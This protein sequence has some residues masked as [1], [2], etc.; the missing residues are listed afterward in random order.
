MLHFWSLAIEEQFYLAWPIVVAGALRWGSVRTVRAAALL[1]VAGS[2]TFSTVVNLAGGSIDQLYLSTT[3]RMGEIGIGAVFATVL[4]LARSRHAGGRR[5]TGATAVTAASI[6]GI[7]AA[8]TSVEQQS[9]W[10]YPTGLLVHAVATCVLIAAACRPGWIQH[11]LGARL[12]GVIGRLSYSLYLVHWPIYLIVDERRTGID[13]LTLF[14]LRLAA[15]VAAASISYGVIGQP[16][17]RRRIVSGPTAG[18]VVAV[19][20]VGAAAS[21][22]L[23][24]ADPPACRVTY[25][26]VS[27]GAGGLTTATAVP[28]S[29]SGARKTTTQPEPS[30]LSPPSASVSSSPAGERP[31]PRGREGGSAATATPGE[32][33]DLERETALLVGDSGMFG[34]APA[35]GAALQQLGYAVIDNSYPGV[36]VADG[37]VDWRTIWGGILDQN[38]VT[39]VI[40]MMGGWDVEFR[41]EHGAEAYAAVL[42]DVAELLTA[43]GATVL[44]ISVLPGGDAHGFEINADLEALAWRFSASVYFYDA[45]ATVRDEQGAYPRYIA[46]ELFRT[47]DG[48][49]LCQAGAASLARGVLQE[50]G[51][52]GHLGAMPDAAWEAGQWTTD[53][54]YGDCETASG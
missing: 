48:W 13:G 53:S 46:G 42:D 28:S 15:S 32:P 47:S 23:L 38:R 16:T 18:V 25:C 30:R 44:W 49:H 21:G 9:R 3:T 37:S 5:S 4:P 41:R 31:S 7:L 51:R 26:N 11:L 40:A 10:L 24:T 8:W 39:L 20:I 1:L 35:I 29:S 2:A 17:R 54:R 19:A 52:L 36:G 34:E 33:V 14:G 27:S 12:P 50:L 6:A 45:S 43:R 22:W